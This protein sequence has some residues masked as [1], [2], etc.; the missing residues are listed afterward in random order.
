[1]LKNEQLSKVQIVAEKVKLK[2]DMSNWLWFAIVFQD[3]ILYIIVEEEISK[4]T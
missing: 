1:M 4:L 3:V 2:N